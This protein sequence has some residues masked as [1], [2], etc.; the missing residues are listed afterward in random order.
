[1]T[2]LSNKGSSNLFFGVFVQKVLMYFSFHYSV[3]CLLH[4]G[5]ESSLVTGIIPE[6]ISQCFM[7]SCLDGITVF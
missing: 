7:Y 1:V 5:P 4:R 6:Y 3:T 2:R